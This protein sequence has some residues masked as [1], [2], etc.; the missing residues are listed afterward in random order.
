MLIAILTK[1]DTL[2]ITPENSIATTQ[3]TLWNSKAQPYFRNTSISL[4]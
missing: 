3:R 2:V 4:F 1:V